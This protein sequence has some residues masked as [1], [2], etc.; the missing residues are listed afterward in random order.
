MGLTNNEYT[1]VVNSKIP[2]AKSEGITLEINENNPF[3]LQDY[4]IIIN[5][6]EKEIANWVEEDYVLAYHY[7]D[8]YS[9]RNFSERVREQMNFYPG[10]HQTSSVKETDPAY[11]KSKQMSED[12]M[13]Y[14]NN[15]MDNP[16]AFMNGLRS[17]QQDFD[18]TKI[19]GSDTS[20][21]TK[22][23]NIGKLLTECVPCFNR[24]LDVNSLIP[25]GDI[26]E[27]HMLNIKARTDVIDKLKGLLKDPGMYVD[28][29]E[30]LNLLSGICPQDLAAMLALLTQ[31]LSKMNLDIKFNLD[32]IMNLVGP[33]LSP[34][35]NALSQWLDKWIQMI[36]G[37]M[38]CVVDHVN[39]VIITSQQMK[40]PFSESS[41]KID[42][43]L[44]IAAPM[45]KNSNF[46]GSNEA[47]VE[48]GTWSNGEF[49]RFNTPD[50]EKY[51]PQRPK[52]PDVEMALAE[53]EMKEAW[54]PSMTESER[55][56]SDQ[57]W[58]DLK[59]KE[60]AKRKKTPAPL[61]PSNPRDGTRWSKDNIPNSEK[62]NKSYSLGDEYYPPEKQERPKSP[63]GYFD[64]SPL[65][66]SIV[67]IRNILQGAI[68]YVNDWFTYITQMVYDLL[69]TDIG[70]MEK[71]TGSSVQ[72][73]RIIQLINIIKSIFTAM[74]QN[75]LKC[76]DNSNFDQDQ[77]KFILEDGLNKYS[78]TK[79]KVLD[80]GDIKV[81]PAGS[82]TLPDAQDLSDQVAEDIENRNV[83]E[84]TKTKEVKQKSIKSGIIVK[85]CLKDLTTE[86][87]N[88]ARQWIAEYEGRY[89]G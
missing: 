84:T 4:S 17:R 16:D 1:N 27:V 30:V 60:R 34:F 36:I 87:L 73:T 78:P 57:M 47:S 88:N 42:T 77:L 37:P 83:A 24:L 10:M 23:E 2:I 67:Q 86:E 15:A 13:G 55:E 65:T 53:D 39:E 89:N 45:H 35:L 43:D 7:K 56:V 58:A 80:N 72:K 51:N 12:R 68:Q 49:E 3:A 81:I 82:N 74:S 25:D 46:E 31:L 52:W 59:E 41:I 75:G 76:G 19:F 6:F 50:S 70:W 38:I 18:Y 8:V 20:A 62:Y 64:A 28:I 48:T 32:F 22:A 9:T 26:L 85:N 14:W 69:G 54:N 40:I 44:G 66:N 71:K 63:E 11:T 79:F 5:A 21:K 33:I 29:C 61:K